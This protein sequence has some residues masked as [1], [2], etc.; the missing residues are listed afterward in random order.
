MR[1]RN[2][3][4]ILGLLAFWTNFSVISHQVSKLLAS[5]PIN[6]KSTQSAKILELLKTQFPHASEK[7]LQEILNQ[8]PTDFLKQIESH[9]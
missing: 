5:I 3:I 6:N 9:K 8:F 7:E 1:A 4:L 2:I